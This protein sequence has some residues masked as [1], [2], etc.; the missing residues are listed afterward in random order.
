M[1]FLWC[2]FGSEKCFGASSQSNYWE[3]VH[4]CCLIKEEDTTKLFFL[5]CSQLMKHTPIKLFH[6]SN[7]F[8]MPND[9]RMVDIEFFGNFS[10]SC[11]RISFYDPSVSHCQL[12]MV[13]DYAPHLQGSPLLC[14]TCLRHH[15]TV[16]SLA[17]PRP[18]VLLTL[19]VVFAVLWPILNSNKKIAQICFLSNIISIL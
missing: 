2:K 10:C 7:W 13:S 14:I 18:N 1:T 5:I 3:M 11:K 15:C 19:W 6:L 12:L 17:V 16:C 9:H 8:Q 4:C